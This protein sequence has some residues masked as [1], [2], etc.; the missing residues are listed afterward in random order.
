MEAIAAQER[1]TTAVFSH[2]HLIALFLNA[3]EK[4]IGRSEAELLTNPDVLKIDW[5]DGAFS[6]DRDFRLQGLAAIATPHSE[7]P[8]EKEPGKAPELIRQSGMA[9]PEPSSKEPRA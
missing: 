6:W 3:L 1:Q 7:T 8:L 9:R 5:K 2:G 4:N